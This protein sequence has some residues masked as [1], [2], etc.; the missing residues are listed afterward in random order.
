M[1]SLCSLKLNQEE[2]RNPEGL[3]LADETVEG[4]GEN[5]PGEE[6]KNE[7]KKQDKVEDGLTQK[8]DLQ[9]E[10][11]PAIQ[12]QLGTSDVQADV[13]P[14]AEEEDGLDDRS[15]KIVLGVKWIQGSVP[16]LQKVFRL[17]RY[18]LRL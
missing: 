9:V 11:Q 1:D 3:S 18:N 16:F 6:K 4:T 17:S 14:N 7:G 8:G 13:E 10:T 12:E 15:V 2:N 5:V